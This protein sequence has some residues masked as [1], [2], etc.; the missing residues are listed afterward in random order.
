MIKARLHSRKNIYIM[1]RS[2][3]LVYYS[4][5]SYLAYFIAENFFGG[6]HYVWCS[7]IYDPSKLEELHKWKRI[8]VSSNPHKIYLSLLEDVESGDLHSDKIRNNINGL[9]RAAVQKLANGD[10]D[11]EE[12]VKI[13]LMI[14]KATPDL[15]K[16]LLYIIPKDLVKTRINVV[17]ITETA[18]ILSEEFQI[19][20][21]ATHEFEIIQTNK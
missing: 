18:G 9:R 3:N 6:K 17:P 4:T 19:V 13:N 5:N 15:F 11:D 10:I 14:D 20:D 16:P 8:P 1:S 2:E 21:L 12:F 7:P